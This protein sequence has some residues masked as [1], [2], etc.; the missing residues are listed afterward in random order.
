MRRSFWATWCLVVGGVAVAGCEADQAADDAAPGGDAAPAG[1][2]GTP[3][4][5]AAP[6]GAVASDAAV[7]A[8]APGQVEDAPCGLNGRGLRRR[9]CPAGAWVEG[10][11]ADPDVCRDGE[12]ERIACEGGEQ[13]RGCVAGRWGEWSAC[14]SPEC[15]DGAS[16][17]VACGINLRGVAARVCEGGRWAAPGP[18]ADPDECVDGAA[19]T[20]ACGAGGMRTRACVAGR[21][22]PWRDCEEP[23][24]CADGERQEEPCGARDSGRRHRTCAGRVWGAWGECEG[25]CRDEC[26][27]GEARCAEGGRQVCG[28]D[29]ADPCVEWPAAEPCAFGCVDAACAE[30]PPAVVI[31][32]ILYD[33]E[34]ADAP[35]VFVE[36]W[37]PP[38]TPLD[39]FRLE[40]VNGNGGGAYNRVPLAGAIPDDGLFVIAHPMA[41]GPLAAV[42]DL[43]HAN[44]D[45]QNGPDSV[46]L[47]RGERVVDAVGYG[48]FAGAVFAGEGAPAIDPPD[49][50][51][52][53]RDAVHTDTGDNARDFAPSVPS[54]GVAEGAPAPVCDGIRIQDVEAA[55]A[56]IPVDLGM[57]EGRTTGSCG[58]AGS[59]E[60]ALRFELR[61]QRLIGF[62]VERWEGPV[63]TL[64]LRRRCDDRDDEIRCVRPGNGYEGPTPPGV[65][66]LIV[67]GDGSG[68]VQLRVQ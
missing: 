13:V 63:P 25:A 68:T 67:D 48:E 46:R 2:G 41:R 39:G 61:V 6:D 14:N 50:Q 7:A 4:G 35:A 36:L 20:Q 64:Y 56:I 31:N 47:M 18:C 38:G 3:D 16:D 49:G 12:S 33:A 34:G 60:V 59:G 26:A 9:T 11:C 55:S 23:G 53:T 24:V 32:E 40:G 37:G 29:D 21:F 65:Y 15:A 30:P 62:S 43:A 27:E 22:E 66:H 45:F 52:L 10:E 42:V 5:A 8:C 28:A 54:P 17:E 51:S 1:D 58:G 44:I 57:L 19:Q